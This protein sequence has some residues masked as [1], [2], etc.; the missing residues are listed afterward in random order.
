VSCKGDG[1]YDED[2]DFTQ[3]ISKAIAEAKVEKLTIAIIFGAYWCPNCRGLS[4]TIDRGK[5]ANLIAK[6]FKV[7]KAN[8]GNFDSNLE[9]ANIYGNP[10]SGGIPGAAILSFDGKLVHVTKP[11]E[12]ANARAQSGEGMYSFFNRTAKN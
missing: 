8:V 5:N 12:L 7:V 11:G 3:E 10:I 4:E 2:S 1:H 9:I 6:D